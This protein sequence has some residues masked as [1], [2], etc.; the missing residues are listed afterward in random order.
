MP[1]FWKAEILLQWLRLPSFHYFEILPG[2]CQYS[3]MATEWR[4]DLG[5]Q[6]KRARVSLGLRQEDIAGQIGIATSSLS[7]Y[8][9]GKKPIDFEILIAIAGALK[10]TFE[11]RGFRLAPTNGATFPRIL[12]KQLCLEFDKEHVFQAT[13]LSIRPTREGTVIIKASALTKTA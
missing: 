8:E 6:I 2:L 1:R 12:P 3:E 5:S 7:Y 13:E 4:Q 9:S 11:A 10:T